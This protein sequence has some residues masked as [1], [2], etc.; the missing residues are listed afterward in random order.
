M[1]PFGQE[2][3]PIPAPLFSVTANDKEK[4]PLP[5]AHDPVTGTGRWLYEEMTREAGSVA[6]SGNFS[7]SPKDGMRTKNVGNVSIATHS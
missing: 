3:L 4:I 6:G 7:R 5:D 2:E 1:G